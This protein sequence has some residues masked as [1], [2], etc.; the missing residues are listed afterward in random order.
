MTKESTSNR[1]FVYILRAKGTTRTK[2]GRTKGAIEDRIAQLQTGNPFVIEE[3]DRIETQHPSKVE[4]YL[5]ALLAVSRGG[6]GEWFELD[7][8]ELGEAVAQARGY[9][10][11]L[12]TTSERLRELSKSDVEDREEEPSHDDR[13]IHLEILSLYAEK[14][15]IETDI[16]RREDALRIRIGTASGLRSIASWRTVESSRLDQ[17]RFKKEQP[18]LFDEFAVVTASRRFVV[19][20]NVE[21]DDE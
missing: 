14:K 11:H 18:D 6:T 4:G 8:Q 10:E 20:R 3:R 21:E 2:I 9:A 1:G 13:A 7:D 15:R 16:A 5:H 17:A 12:D 19:S